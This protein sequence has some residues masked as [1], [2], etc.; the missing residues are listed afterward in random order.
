M[1]LCQG[2]ENGAK[3]GRVRGGIR[4]KVGF[5]VD[6]KGQ[7]TGSRFRRQMGRH[8]RWRGQQGAKFGGLGHPTFTEAVLLGGRPLGTVRTKVAGWGWP[9]APTR[10]RPWDLVVLPVGSSS[11]WGGTL[12]QGLTGQVGETGWAAIPETAQGVC[13]REGRSGSLG[14][15]GARQVPWRPG[16]GWEAWIG[17][18]ASLQLLSLAAPADHMAWKAF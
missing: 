5:E 3:S 16:A 2:I 4:E 10:Q 11:A 1:I 15:F 7:G 9:L 13:Q 14:L 8:F 6:P 18:P 17:Q 12:G